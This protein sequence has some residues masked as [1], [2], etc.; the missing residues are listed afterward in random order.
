M[1]SSLGNAQVCHQQ[2]CQHGLQGN[3]HKYHRPPEGRCGHLAALR[4]GLWFVGRNL[5]KQVT[6]TAYM[7]IVYIFMKT[8]EPHT[9]VHQTY[10]FYTFF[11][12]GH[13]VFT[14]YFQNIYRKFRQYLQH[15]CTNFIQNCSTAASLV[16]LVFPCLSNSTAFQPLLGCVFD[17]CLLFLFFAGLS[18][19]SPFVSLV[20]NVFSLTSLGFPYSASRI[21][22]DGF[23]LP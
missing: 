17:F 7:Y 19:F 3:H 12:Y 13:W 23:L 2:Q 16:F 9:D 11:K 4:E 18:R 5:E 1:T 8:L 14:K 6:Y 22:H 15:I 10:F 20:V 21:A